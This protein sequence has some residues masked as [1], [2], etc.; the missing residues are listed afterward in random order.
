MRGYG[1]A[2][3]ERVCS[4]VFWGESESGCAHLLALRPKGGDNNGDADQAETFRGRVVADCVGWSTAM[5]LL[6]E[7]DGDPRSKWTGG[8]AL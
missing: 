3:A 2:R 8:R 1:S 5:L 6:A 7:E 4:D